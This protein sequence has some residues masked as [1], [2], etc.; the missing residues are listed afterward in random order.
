[1]ALIDDVR[2]AATAE[3]ASLGTGFVGT[4]HLFL[5]WLMTAS[6]P[7]AD[8]VAAAGLT[9]DVFRTLLAQGKNSGRNQAPGGEGGVSTRAAKVLDLMAQRASAAGREEATLDDLLLALVQEPHGAIARA[10]S[11][12]SLKPSRLKALGRG[13]AAPQQSSP[14]YP[15]K[16]AAFSARQPERTESA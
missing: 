4:E 1:M 15:R 14:A 7:L 3:A 11:A 5:V 9:A 6:G 12:H 8:A 16:Q 2:T 13:A 10:L